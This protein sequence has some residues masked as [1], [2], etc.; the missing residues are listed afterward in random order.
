MQNLTK[1]EHRIDIHHSDEKNKPKVIE[2]IYF[3]ANLRAYNGTLLTQIG[4]MIRMFSH[5]SNKL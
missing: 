1:F 5:L 4:D 3:V 2:K